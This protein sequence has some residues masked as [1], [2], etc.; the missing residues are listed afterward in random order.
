MRDDDILIL[1]GSEINSLLAGQ[2][3]RIIDIV[4]IAYEA[5]GWGES[6]LPH[7]T[8]LRFPDNPRDRFRPCKRDCSFT[9]STLPT[10]KSIST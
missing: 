5:H 7:S 6:S 3:L 1:K 10:R 4:R 8:F 9:R 2:E